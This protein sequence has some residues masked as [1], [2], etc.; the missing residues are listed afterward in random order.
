M[1]A[2]AWA[3][4]L[5]VEAACGAPRDGVPARASAAEATAR[6][7]P[8]P[9]LGDPALPSSATFASEP[10]ENGI[11]AGK[12]AREVEEH[13]VGIVRQHGGDPRSDARLAVL[14]R[15]AAH[16]LLEGERPG[17]ALIDAASRR[18]GHIGPAPFIVFLR[19]A[20]FDRLSG[21]AVEGELR[22]QIDALPANLVLT[23][24]GTGSAAGADEVVVAFVVGSV[25]LSMAPVPKRLT[26]GTSVHLAG[27][28]SD[29]YVGV[30]MAIACPDGRVRSARWSGRV[31]V[32]DVILPE[33]GAYR[34][35][36]L[37]EG[38]EG[39]VV[40][41]NF[42]VYVDTEEPE[43]P[44]P[45]ASADVSAGPALTAAR[46]E[47]RLLAL[48]NEARAH[49]HLAALVPDAELASVAR[50]HSEDMAEHAFF[51][52]VSPWTGGPGDRLRRLAEPPVR[53][54]ENV[55]RAASPDDA[56][57]TL[58][59]SPAHRANMLDAGF[60]HVGVGAAVR[61]RPAGVRL[62]HVTLVFAQRPR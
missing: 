19:A 8:D 10:G 38:S 15:W 36:L 55:A 57:A 17:A 2:V 24:Y 27:R 28:V 22:R 56:Y 1:H 3:F 33:P 9:A 12:D 35:E 14:A 47:A 37:G 48:V 26:T 6:A 40:V 53:F 49:E 21:D 31:F 34:V 52:H 39:P 43:V 44:P 61:D 23:R 32:T 29:R 16:R 20:H 46:A 25:E 18:V 11:D 30:R 13:A 41:A 51:G 54:G 60:T 50:A 7:D 62:L 5:V 59:G 45:G 58:M 42:P 4:G